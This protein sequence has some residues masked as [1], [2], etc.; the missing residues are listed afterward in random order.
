MR[1]KIIGGLVGVGL[2]LSAAGLG[3]GAGIATAEVY[4][5]EGDQNVNALA[6][7]VAAAGLVSNAD[8]T[9]ATAVDVC[10]KHAQGMTRDSEITWL[11]QAYSPSVAVNFVVG[12]EFHFCPAY[13][14]LHMGDNGGPPRSQVPAPPLSPPPLTTVAPNPTPNPTPVQTARVVLNTPSASRRARTI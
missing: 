10:F 5:A 13:D 14:S 8:Q 3:T 6:A 4:G 12:S 9:R 1:N 2:I 7:E 11:E